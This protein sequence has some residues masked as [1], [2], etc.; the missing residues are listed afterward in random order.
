MH[1]RDASG[2]GGC[3]YP[4]SV[5]VSHPSHE[6]PPDLVQRVFERRGRLHAY[7]S[8]APANTALVV[9]DMDAASAARQIEEATR[10]AERINR[11]GA[12]LAEAGGTVAFVTSVIGDPADFERRLGTAAARMYVA[13]T[14]GA[15]EGTALFDGLTVRS[16]DLRH[17]KTGASAFFSDNCGLPSA[18]AQRDIRSVLIAG[19]V[20]NICCES[21][22][23][24]ATELGYQVTMVSDANI[25]QSYGLHEA[26]LATFFRYFGDVRTTEDV[27]AL[28][29]RQRA[30]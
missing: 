11:I 30:G 6:I 20:T 5:A 17:I 22:A 9:V 27:I 8:L 4:A 18:L 14:T 23:R 15:G 25:G 24:D 13:E 3:P 2:V 29:A 16:S 26:S 21:S 19:L 1:R 28:I 10:A 12:A 7:E